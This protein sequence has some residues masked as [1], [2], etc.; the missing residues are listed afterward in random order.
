MFGSIKFLRNLTIFPILVSL[1]TFAEAGAKITVIEPSSD[2]PTYVC[3]TA[4]SI[5][6]DAGYSEQWIKTPDH[7]ETD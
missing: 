7:W 6:I 2:C 5:Y 1:G 4:Y 3:G